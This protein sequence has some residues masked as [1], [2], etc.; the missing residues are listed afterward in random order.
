MMVQL[1]VSIGIPTT[2]EGRTDMEADW[3]DDY[4]KYLKYRRNRSDQAQTDAFAL[5]HA[6]GM[7]QNLYQRI[8]SDLARFVGETGHRID[9]TPK[10]DHASQIQSHEFPNV[11]MHFELGHGT[12]RVN[13]SVKMDSTASQQSEKFSIGIVRKGQGKIYFRLNG[14]DFARESVLSGVLLKP[15]FDLLP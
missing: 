6:Q 9:V 7:L 1:L 12:I 10:G 2:F 11:F 13:K 4:L 8:K 15:M 3:T 5:E 14:E